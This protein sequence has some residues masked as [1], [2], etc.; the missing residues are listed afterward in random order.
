MVPFYTRYRLRF[1]KTVVTLGVSGAIQHL[2]G[3]GGAKTIIAVN[4]DPEAPIFSVADYA[5]VEIVWNCCSGYWDKKKCRDAVPA[6]R[7]F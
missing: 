3:I 1:A 4:T 2:A 6:H 5:I 7:C